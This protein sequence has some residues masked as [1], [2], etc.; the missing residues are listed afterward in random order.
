[1]IRADMIQ[2]RAF[3]PQMVSVKM[4]KW[5]TSLRTDR[6]TTGPRIHPPLCVVMRVARD[7]KLWPRTAHTGVGMRKVRD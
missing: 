2:T 1:M 3:N 7:I 5:M 4:T 6:M